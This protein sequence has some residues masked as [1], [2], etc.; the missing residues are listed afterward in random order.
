MKNWFAIL[1]D[2][3]INYR[4]ALHL[5]YLSIIPVYGLSVLVV[6]GYVSSDQGINI[7]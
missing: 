2:N 3:H 7:D 4:R 6:S 5:T 1:L